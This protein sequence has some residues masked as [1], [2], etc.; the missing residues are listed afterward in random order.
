MVVVRG[1]TMGKQKYAWTFDE[2]DEYWKSGMLDSI[3]E[4]LAEAEIEN[5]LDNHQHKYVYVGWCE[6]FDIR[7]NAADILERLEEDADDEFGEVAEEWDALYYKL[8]KADGSLDELSDQIT[9]IVTEW[10]KN[11]KRLPGFYKIGR[12]EKFPL[13]MTLTLK[14]ENIDIVAAPG[15][16]L[17]DLQLAMDATSKQISM[18]PFFDEEGW[19]CKNCGVE[20]D[21]N[22][23]YC[24][25]CGQLQDWGDVDGTY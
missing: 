10:L 4:C 17:L 13:K 15:N 14:Q 22:D 11:K 3:E 25:Y 24:F 23:N 9:N 5:E 2:D 18:K 7:V 8:D 19:C 6:E 12:I 1:V 16:A 21:K 20:I